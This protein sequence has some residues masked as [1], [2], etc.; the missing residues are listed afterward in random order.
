MAESPKGKQAARAG[1][2]SE[3][4]AKRP[5]KKPS[6]NRE[7]WLAAARQALIQEGTAGVEV[8]KLAKRLGSSRS[9]FY[10]FFEDRAQ[11]LTQ[12]LGYWAQS[13]TQLLEQI[14]L[15]HA[16]DGMAAY[17][18]VG[19]FWLDEVRYDPKWDGA[20][21]DWARTSEPVRKLWKMLTRSES[22]SW[23]AFSFA[24]ATSG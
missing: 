12:L 3:S 1:T 16:H 4:Q 11:L 23:S 10:W 7:A 22:L 2:R 5:R 17:R 15:E 14:A 8:N 13:S 9:S 21:R 18:A 19:N 20:V 6:L 24:W